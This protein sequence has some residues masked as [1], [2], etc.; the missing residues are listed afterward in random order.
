MIS[1]FRTI[2]ILVSIV[3][4]PLDVRQKTHEPG[5]LNGLGDFPLMLGADAGV[6]RIDNLHLTGNKTPEKI[7][8]FIIYV[9]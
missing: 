6:L 1:I 9:R 2:C 8:L 5:T 4:L 7:N 3:V